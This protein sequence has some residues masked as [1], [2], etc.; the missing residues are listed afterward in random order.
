MQALPDM[1]VAFQAQ[2]N[3]QTIF[4]YQRHLEHDILQSTRIDLDLFPNLL[5]FA[6]AWILF[7]FNIR[8]L[9]LYFSPL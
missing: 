2:T 8:M 6:S 3:L 7:K 9:G 5:T 1:C 4:K